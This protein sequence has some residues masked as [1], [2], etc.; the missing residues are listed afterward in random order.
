MTF[1]LIG[2]SVEGRSYD[3]NEFV[4]PRTSP[5]SL[6]G[7][8]NHEASAYSQFTRV[9]CPCWSKFCELALPLQRET[10]QHQDQQNHW[11]PAR[12]RTSLAA[13]EASGR[14]KAPRRYCLQG[15]LLIDDHAPTVRPAAQVGSARSGSSTETATVPFAGDHEDRSSDS[16]PVFAEEIDS[17]DYSNAA[18]SVNLF[19]AGAAH[20]ADLAKEANVDTSWLAPLH[21]LVRRAADAG[22]GSHS[23]SAL[24]EVLRKSSS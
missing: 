17:G 2:I 3:V 10:G 20:D 8:I 6:P 5:N 4:Q 21:D 23:I 14:W 15:Q 19:V 9:T 1:S 18:S 13:T 24:T 11:R 7:S 12:A 16:V 22:Y